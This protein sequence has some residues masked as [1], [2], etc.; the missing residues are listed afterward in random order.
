MTL[1]LTNQKNYVGQV[2]QKSCFTVKSLDLNNAHVG[3]VSRDPQL[4]YQLQQASTSNLAGISD[5]K[6]LIRSEAQEHSTS[7]SLGMLSPALRLAF[8]P[9]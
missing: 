3:Y 7:G 8:M 1:L 2:A 4:L 6:W 5:K 9:W